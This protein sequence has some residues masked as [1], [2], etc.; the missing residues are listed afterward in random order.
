MQP[1]R[2]ARVKA[3]LENAMARAAGTAI[4]GRMS[5]TAAVRLVVTLMVLLDGVSS[6]ASPGRCSRPRR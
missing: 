1:D 6:S 2:R 4:G 5:S 3:A